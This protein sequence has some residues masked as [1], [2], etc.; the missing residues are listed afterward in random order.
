MSLRKDDPVY[1]KVKLNALIRQAKEKGLQV[2]CQNE[3]NKIII[4]FKADNGDVASFI[5]KED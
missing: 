1:Y 3:E 2:A 4:T 5:M